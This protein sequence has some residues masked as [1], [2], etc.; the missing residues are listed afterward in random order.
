VGQDDEHFARAGGCWQA[1][2]A[3][4]LVKAIVIRR[5]RKKNEVLDERCGSPPS[6]TSSAPKTPNE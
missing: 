2:I 5:R 4:A 1:Y 6:A 3:T